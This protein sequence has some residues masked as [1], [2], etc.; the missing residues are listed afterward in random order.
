M[1][2]LRGD[3]AEAYEAP[4]LGIRPEHIIVTTEIK[5]SWAVSVQF[6]ERLG[7]ETYV[8]SIHNNGQ[9]L[10]VRVPGD[11]TVEPGNRL[12]VIPDRNH[13]HMFDANGRRRHEPRSSNK[14][15]R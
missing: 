2:I 3:L 7:S 11:Y 15:C 14:Q 1:N 5:G 10:V 9:K 6:S 13:L 4:V 12:S 8:H